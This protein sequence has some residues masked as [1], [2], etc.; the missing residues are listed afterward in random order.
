[1]NM[2]YFDEHIFD[3]I[4]L[5]NSTQL[6]KYRNKHG[7]NKIDAMCSKFAEYVFQTWKHYHKQ[8]MNSDRTDDSMLLIYNEYKQKLYNEIVDNL[9]VL[10]SK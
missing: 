4:I 5:L 8:L 10:D 2:D 7:K 1:M 3:D 9:I 6:N